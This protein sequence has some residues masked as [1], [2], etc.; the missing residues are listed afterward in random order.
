MIKRFIYNVN[1]WATASLRFP[2]R[3]FQKWLAADILLFPKITIKS[4]EL[5]QG[6]LVVPMASMKFF[7]T[8]QEE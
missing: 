3:F 1:A 4:Y 5:H 8:K 6:L 2:D 7:L